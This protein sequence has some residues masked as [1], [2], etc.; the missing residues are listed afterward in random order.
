MPSDKIITTRDSKLQSN[1]RAV[2]EALALEVFA[3]V[4]A[5]AR[6]LVETSGV[7]D[8]SLYRVLSKLL[9]RGYVTQAQKGDPYYISDA[10]RRAITDYQE[11]INSGASW[12][13]DDD[14]PEGPPPRGGDSSD[15]ESDSSE[16]E[17]SPEY[18]S[19]KPNYHTITGYDGAEVIEP[20]PEGGELSPDYHDDTAPGSPTITSITD[21][22]PTIDSDTSQLSSPHGYHRYSREVESAAE[23]E[24]DSMDAPAAPAPPQPCTI[25]HRRRIES[26]ALEPA[27][28]PAPDTP[29]KPA[30][31]SPRVLSRSSG[32]YLTVPLP[33][34]DASADAA[35]VGKVLDASG[36]PIGW[37]WDSSRSHTLV[38]NESGK[39]TS[40]D[41]SKER[42]IVE[43]LS[44]ALDWPT[45]R[46][47]AA[48]EAYQQ[49]RRE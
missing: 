21:Y 29:R 7:P 49:Q 8:G 37:H 15:S 6:K 38:H 36:I 2:L 4:G 46:A 44:I 25:P 32:Q 9:K 18:G 14:P 11:S 30:R 23:M 1:E 27:P 26:T 17:L 5:S 3:K 10:G 47:H 48:Y 22:H 12:G 40:M 42:V 45:A 28:A 24:S 39:S 31:T 41:V 33:T 16:L 13:P 19:T 43:A 20:A 34:P 35:E